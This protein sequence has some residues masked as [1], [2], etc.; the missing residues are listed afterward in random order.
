MGKA[1]KRL[2]S[3]SLSR[4]S[5]EAKCA[6][7]QAGMGQ[8]G[9]DGR[10]AEKG[11]HDACCMVAAELVLPDFKDCMSAGPSPAAPPASPP[12]LE[13]TCKPGTKPNEVG[14][15]TCVQSGKLVLTSE[16]GT[17]LRDRAFYKCK[18]LE[19]VDISEVTEVGKEAFTGCSNLKT[20][21]MPNAIK[22]G[23][24]AFGDT[25]LVSLHA[26][27]AIEVGMYACWGCKAL[28]SVDLP[29]A[30]TVGHYA[31]HAC[32]AL[33]AVNISEVT[34]VKEA[35]FRGC[36]NLKTVTMPNA[37]KIGEGAFE[38]CS[39]L[40]AVSMPK[41]TYI[42][43]YAFYLC[44]DLETVTMPMVTK[45]AAGAFGHTDALKP[46]DRTG[47]GVTPSSKWEMICD[48]RVKRCDD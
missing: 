4:G 25:A 41:V 15:S 38:E 19:T 47:M 9:K 22:I 2:Q 26:P 48:D 6:A 18:A 33:E 7:C 29:L 36:T 13:S 45:I 42:D 30:T 27:K 39:A 8:E 31:F 23:Q 43:K 35:A 12:L 16:D 21:K 34:E 10:I 24:D 17:S 20:V 1:R 11:W 46:H 40:K 44:T 3:G 37:I 5:Y 32:Q 28:E 14:C